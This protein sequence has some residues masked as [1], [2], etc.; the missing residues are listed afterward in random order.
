[1]THIEDAMNAMRDSFGP[2]YV[3]HTNPD[4]E[5]YTLFWRSK[6]FDFGHTIECNCVV[7]KAGECLNMTKLLATDESI[8][9]VTDH[10]EYQHDILSLVNRSN[11][12][13]SMEEAFADLEVDDV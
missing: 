1:M 7:E 5:T 12:T 4:I 2:D 10:I 8:A 13:V 3:P 6:P 9:E 11:D